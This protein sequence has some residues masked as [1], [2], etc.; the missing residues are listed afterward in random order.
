M[1]R[2]LCVIFALFPCQIKFFYILYKRSIVSLWS[3]VISTRCLTSETVKDLKTVILPCK[4]NC[5]IR[6]NF[7]MFYFDNMFRGGSS[8]AAK[9]KMERFVI[10]VNGFQPLPIITKHSILDVAAVLDPPLMFVKNFILLKIFIIRKMNTKYC[11]GFVINT[12]HATECLLNPIQ[13]T[14]IRQ[15]HILSS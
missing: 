9:S 13:N 8:A 5:L 3:F 2:V 14:N 10:I 1:Q 7:K 15:F 12:F 4:V 6:H 11:H